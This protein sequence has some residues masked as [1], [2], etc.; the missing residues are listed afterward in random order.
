M[1]SGLRYTEPML[2]LAIGL[3]W[4]WL[5]FMDRSRARLWLMWS[6]LA[7]TLICWPPVE[8]LCSRPLE[9][10]YPV[11]PFSPPAGLEAIVVFAGSV[12]P[13]QYERP[14]PLPDP[15]TFERCQYAVWVYRQSRRPIL[16][17]GGKGTPR[18][19]AFA[20]TMRNLLVAANVP[21]VD[22][23][24]EDRSISTHENAV[25]SAGILRRQGVHRIA[26]VVDARSMRR[27][28]ACFRKLGIEVV[29]A[30]S[31]FDDL[32]AT[33]D[34]WLLSWKAV[35]GNEETLHEALGLLLYRLRGWI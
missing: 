29:P 22:I 1:L 20:I 24:V 4:V 3:S 34:D 5:Y 10:G 19:P 30:P 31:R 25:F 6:L 27:A 33:I 18:D 26:L 35:R 14:Y 11:R 2:T 8:Y 21:P 12:S 7:V 23:W 28:A 16:T 32:S 13:A 9:W 15:E 17:S